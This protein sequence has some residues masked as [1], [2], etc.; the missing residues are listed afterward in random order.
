LQL[1]RIRKAHIK[2]LLRD[3]FPAEGQNGGAIDRLWP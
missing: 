3:I 2:H 1:I